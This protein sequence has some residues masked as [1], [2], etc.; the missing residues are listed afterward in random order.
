MCAGVDRCHYCEDSAADEVEHLR[1]KNL[2]PGQTFQWDNY[3]FA[4]GPCN[5]P[6]R[7]RF[8]VLTRAGRTFVNM[9]EPEPG[10]PE[11][12]LALLL[13]PRTEDPMRFL[14]L[15]LA[16]TFHFAPLHGRSCLAGIRAAYTIQVLRLNRDRLA[17]RRAHAYEDYLARLREYAAERDPAVR[18]RLRASILRKD[19]PTVFRE[20]QR[21]HARLP[22]LRPLFE[23]VPEA[24]GW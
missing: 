13:H 20:M 14:I 2:Y 3:L 21:Q 12:E 22:E 4:C 11:D 23:Q 10:P 18:D 24:R 17:A 8:G 15:D 5:G 16:Q 19:H 7:D 6:K 1:P 9:A